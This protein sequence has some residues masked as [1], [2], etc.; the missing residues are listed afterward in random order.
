MALYSLNEDDSLKVS[1]K[2]PVDSSV[3]KFYD[4]ITE[5]RDLNGNV[6]VKSLPN[7]YITRIEITVPNCIFYFIQKTS[8]KPVSK[9]A[10]ITPNQQ[11]ILTNTPEKYLLS[12][13]QIPTLLQTKRTFLTST[14]L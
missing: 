14:I 6:I 12:I 8:T 5:I 1:V 2:F 13:K 3:D 10:T 7:N 4:F 11:T 9:L